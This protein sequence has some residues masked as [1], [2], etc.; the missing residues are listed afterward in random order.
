MK[1]LDKKENYLKVNLQCKNCSTCPDVTIDVEND[2][3]LLE[4][5][6]GNTNKWTVENFRELASQIKSGAFDSYLQI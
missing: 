2:K 1:Y 5:D 3:V 4:D 6:H